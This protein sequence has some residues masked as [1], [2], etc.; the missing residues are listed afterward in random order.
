MLSTSDDLHL[1]TRTFKLVFIYNSLKNIDL[2]NL[3]LEKYGYCPRLLPKCYWPV[4]PPMITSKLRCYNDFNCPLDFKCCADPCFGHKVCRQLISVTHRLTT[5]A[6][7]PTTTTI[8]KTTIPTTTEYQDLGSGNYNDDEFGDDTD[9]EDDS[10]GQP[11]ET[12]NKLVS[13]RLS[14]TSDDY[15]DSD[16]LYFIYV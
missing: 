1:L 13:R 16:D 10:S 12:H 2:R 7:N 11:L 15:H 8:K 14:S 5:D 4:L 3:F 9:Y 6:P